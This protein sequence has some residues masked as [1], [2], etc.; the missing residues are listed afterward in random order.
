M[1]KFISISMI[2]ILLITAMPIYSYATD[3]NGLNLSETLKKLVTR[4]TE[5]FKE[6][7]KRFSDMGNHWADATVGKLVE[8][9]IL[10]GYGDG[11]FRPDNTITRAEFAK[12]VRTSLKLDLKEGNNFNDT[13]NHW[14][15][16]EI[17]TL[18]QENIIVPSEYGQNYEPDKNITRVEMAKMIVRAVGL[19]EKAKEL[20]GQKTK[21]NDDNTIKSEDKGYIIIASEN[22][23]IN[24]YPDN[25]FKPNGEATR[26]EASQMIVNM[27][28]ALD[29]GIEIDED[30]D[31]YKELKE[32]K[33]IT[34][35]VNEYME[36]GE[37]DKSEQLALWR[38]AKDSRAQ[39]LAKYSPTDDDT[40][41]PE[42]KFRIYHDYDKV[43]NTVFFLFLENAREY[44]EKFTF[45]TEVINKDL[46]CLNYFEGV[47]N[48]QGDRRI[49]RTDRKVPWN[50]VK[51][52]GLLWR[53]DSRYYGTFEERDKIKLK[54][55]MEIKLK[56]TITNTHTNESK[57]Y[58]NKATIKTL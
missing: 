18:V 41:F 35:T 56:T 23:I 28:D 12:V 57:V 11:T 22:G 50:E 49:F 5:H 2:L 25:T 39:L 36:D 30:N 51:K 14:A 10:D 48:R 40:A 54:N 19:D 29:K 13:K 47:I 58:Y 9:G 55:G 46:D 21:F 6:L 33:E 15:K 42:P 27:F 17:Y 1:K 31:V 16:D 38:K 43:S 26:A 34:D 37:L 24:G 44:N 45:K 53:L 7:V 3:G 32:D 52:S 20:V 4:T 8:L